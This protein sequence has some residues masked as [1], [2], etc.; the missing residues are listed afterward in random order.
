MI[1]LRNTEVNMMIDNFDNK[2]QNQTCH[3]GGQN[4]A[5]ASIS[6]KLTKDSLWFMMQDIISKNEEGKNFIPHDLL[7]WNVTKMERLKMRLSPKKIL[8]LIH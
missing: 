6:I 5:I 4:S 8:W 2:S 3:F 1:E 7:T